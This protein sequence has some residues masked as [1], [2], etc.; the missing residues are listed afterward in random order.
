MGGLGN[1]MFQIATTHAL[2]LRNNDISG[3]Y[4]DACSTPLQGFTSTKYKEN[5]FS[6]IIDCK[7]YNFRC[8]YSEP[9]FSYDELPYT[10]DLKLDG[11]FQSEKYFIDYKQEIIDLFQISANDIIK[12]KEFFSWWGVYDKPITSVHIR[13]GDYLKLQDFHHVCEID[14]FKNAIAEIGDSYFVF[15]SDDMEWV[16]QNFNDKDYIF[17]DFNDELLDLTI[18]TQCDNN[19]ISNSS[20]SW[21]GAYLNKNKHKKVIAPSKWFGP[22]GPKDQIDIIPENWIIC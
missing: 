9:K 11:Y 18:M 17:S 13:R 12:V 19:I 16:K 2:A 22:L 5:I 21:W 15:I 4:F 7:D 3:F 14:Y 6:K 10:K 20:F 1:Q 8:V